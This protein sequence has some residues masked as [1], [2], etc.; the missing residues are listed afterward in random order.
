MFGGDVGQTATL[1]ILGSSFFVHPQMTSD[2][3]QNA[4]M[5]FFIKSPSFPSHPSIRPSLMISPVRRSPSLD[6]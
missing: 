6:A 4:N 1:T 3:M 5:I 2:R